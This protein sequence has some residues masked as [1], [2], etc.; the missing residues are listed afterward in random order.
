M[1][2]WVIIAAGGRGQRL[3]A[4]SSGRPKQFL[5]FGGEPL[6]WR[7]ALP[8]ARIARVRGVVFV[9]PPDFLDAARK[10]VARLALRDTPG[11]AWKI[12][13]GGATR[14]DSVRKGLTAVPQEADAVLI[15]D[16]ARPFVDPALINR[17]LD[18]LAAGHSGVVPGMAVTDTIK[19]IDADNRVAATPARD[20]LRAVQTP[21]GFDPAALRRAHDHAARLGLG[22]T[23]D[24]ALLEL[25]GQAVLVVDGDET[26]RKITTPADLALLQSAG[27]EGSMNAPLPVTG[28]G[29][30]VHRYGGDRP[31]ML[32]GVPI[33]CE[34]AVSAHSDGD[35]LLH[36]LMD[37]L[38]G[39]AGRGDI[40]TLFPDSAPEFDGISSGILLAEVLRLTA[41]C[42]LTLT[43]ADL[44]V[45]AQVPKV[46]P[47][48]EQIAKNIA[49]LLQLP[50][51]SVNV[52]ATTEER[53]GFTGEKLGIKAYA[54]VTG[55]KR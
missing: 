29:Y 5:S 44:T 10:D 13:S 32:G 55:L 35:V 54:V 50:I 11:L 25:L 17:V 27:P 8:F 6:Y 24:A 51:A 41:Q 14:Q 22:A 1:Q 15:H 48:R 46:A 47:Y 3:A 52:K 42:G 39:C 19:E 16:A 31:F 45:V 20:R 38:L 28:F 53:L 12:A 33:P 49:S 18:A 37:A 21:Q 36:A 34:F 7:S 43:H 4:Y 23:D 26:N 30:D 40:G 9:F 2:C